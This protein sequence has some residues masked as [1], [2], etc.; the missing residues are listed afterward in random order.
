MKHLF[1]TLIATSS[2]LIFSKAT[3]AQEQKL[4]VE[5]YGYV[6]FSLGKSPVQPAQ[7]QE[8]SLFGCNTQL[9]TRSLLNSDGKSNLSWNKEDQVMQVPYGHRKNG[10]KEYYVSKYF[11]ASPPVM[12]I[13]DAAPNK[14]DTLA[15]IGLVVPDRFTLFGEKPVQRVYLDYNI[16][17]KVYLNYVKV[18][19]DYKAS[20]KDTTCRDLGVDLVPLNIQCVDFPWDST[21]AIKGAKGASGIGRLRI[22]SSEKVFLLSRQ[23]GEDFLNCGITILDDILLNHEVSFSHADG[24]ESKSLNLTDFYENSDHKGVIQ[25]SCKSRTSLPSACK[26]KGDL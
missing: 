14:K 2:I 6:S 1:F 24:S 18:S 17:E 7:Q 25:L 19:Y 20:P 26:K 10:N 4:E 23:K 21:K 16:L 5:P 9:S 15:N 8:L 22:N 13:M 3:Q 11:M 12:Q